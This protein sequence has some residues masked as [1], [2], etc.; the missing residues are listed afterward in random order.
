M[1]AACSA[2]QFGAF[3]PSFNAGPGFAEIGQEIRWSGG[4]ASPNDALVIIWF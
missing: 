3:T 4:I 1:K 2:V